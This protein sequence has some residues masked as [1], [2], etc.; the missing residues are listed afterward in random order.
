VPEEVNEI[1]DAG[2]DYNGGH[3]PDTIRFGD[4]E[5]PNVRKASPPHTMLGTTQKAW[6]LAQLREASATWKIWGNSLGSLD[7]RTD[8]QN[9]PAGITKPWPGAGY[10]GFGGGDWSGYVTERAEVYDFVRENRITGF[11]TVSGDRHSFW[12]GLAA[13]E[14]PPKRFEPV[15]VA[16]VTASLSAPGLPESAEHN[17]PRDH[18]LRSLFLHQASKDAPVQRTMNMLLMHGVRSCLEYAKSGDMSKAL[19][20]SNPAVA[21]H[22]SFL[23]LG[24][25]G[26]AVVSA[27]KATMDVEF[28][29]IPRPLERSPGNDGGPLLYRVVHQ[30]KLWRA[31]ETPKLQRTL[32]EGEVPLSI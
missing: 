19:A 31:G 28:V 23:D 29:C 4:K 24:G 1:F 15:G 3:P 11:A 2:R 20:V 9:L 8:P 18:P 21:P 17:F 7:W 25:H 26:Y 30:A 10:A 12:A 27:G 22:L 16:F 5:F 6:F 32:L 14:L 13:K